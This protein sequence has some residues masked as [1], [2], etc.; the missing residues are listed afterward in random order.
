[1][2]SLKDRGPLGLNQLT[3]S[4]ASLKLKTGEISSEEIT[5]DCLDRI[6]AR[7]GDILAWDYLNPEYALE[8]AR[9]LDK[10]PRRGLLHGVPIGIKDIFD[11]KDMPT[12]HGFPPY[13][14]Q[15]FG[16]DSV[17]VAQLRD[18]GMVLLGKTVTTEFA[19]PM[20]RQTLNPHDPARTPGVSS[21]GSA[22]S[23]ADY[24]VPVANGT[25]TG[26]SIIGPAANCGVYGY[27]AS[28]E[29]IDRG[30]FRHC[31]KSIDTIG[32]F[33]RSIDDLI[34]LRR[35]QTGCNPGQRAVRLRVGI[36]RAPLWDE[37]EPAMQKMI[38]IINDILRAAG[39][40][41]T[42][43]DLP[44]LFMDIIPDAAIINAW[45]AS[46]ML[47]DEIRDHY[48]S[49]NQHNRERIEW[50][51]GLEVEDYLRAGKKLDIARSEMDQLFSNWDLILS[52]SLPGEPPLGLTEVRTATFAR[53]WT[54]MYTPSINFPLFEGPNEM[55][56]CFQVVGR[57]DTDDDTLANAKWVD[58]QLRSELGNIPV[59]C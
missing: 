9:A 50:V 42:D 39:A 18:A 44:P 32:L 36:L 13:Q 58:D 24:M 8:Q 53:L 55:P 46:V 34:L 3:A 20:P 15:K 2:V 4:E 52:P 10:S 47:K 21:S 59:R 45:E 11:T 40:V 22:A 26:G 48:E 31:K 56:L 57:R 23:V 43:F 16:V 54:Q 38:E 37:A 51:K 35:A 19:C 1:M 49:F 17:C 12:G 27:K 33:A 7:E 41:V 25:Q 6:Q 29:G 5:R 30:G 28:L 14:G